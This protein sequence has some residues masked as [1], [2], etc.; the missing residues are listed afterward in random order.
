[1]TAITHI[2]CPVDFS[3]FSRH[4]LDSAVAIARQ[5]QAAV[6]ALYVVP[7]VQSAN[8]ALGVGAYVQYVYSV[9]DLREFQKTTERFVANVGYP[10]RA[11]VVEATVVAEIVKWAAE[12]PAD[13][14]VIGTHGR[15]GF[16]RLFLG[17]VTE[18]VLAKAPCPVLTIPPRS[19]DVAGATPLFRN[20]LCPIDF[21]SSS[22]A[23]LT[24]A[25]GL[26]REPGAKLT[27]LHV[28]E[29]LPA[30]QLVPAMA[31]GAPDDPLVVLK[32]SRERLHRAIPQAARR[33]AT[34]NELVSEGHAGDEIL[35]AAGEI[36]SDLIVMGAHAGH[37]GLL[38]F[39]STTA[40]VI[41]RATCP[42]LTL[43]A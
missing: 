11:A 15:S 24:Y 16:D 41:R 28:V 1:M 37:A 38:G 8:P 12:L 22:L 34:V 26:A 21:S 31:T 9:E 42:V 17:S 27:V 4:A 10:V 6:T 32:E 43:K 40:R 39:G 33:A 2:L 14:I 35:S 29:R 36:A 19:P 7:P 23:A 3:E 13:L 5:H 18:R 25:E 30:F 20:L